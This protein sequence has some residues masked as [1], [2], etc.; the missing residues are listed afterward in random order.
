ML[1]GG[2]EEWK[3]KILY[4][5]LSSNASKQD[6]LSFLQLAEVSKFFGGAPQTGVTEKE[7][8]AVKQLPK[9]QAP[10]GSTPTG[11]TKKKKKEGC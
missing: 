8:S 5:S 6:S 2:L 9:L 1:L 7:I 10:A 4:P 3:D 11:V